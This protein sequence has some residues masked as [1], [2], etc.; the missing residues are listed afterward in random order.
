[1]SS[2][3][4]IHRRALLIGSA[5]LATAAAAAQAQGRR[6][7]VAYLTRSGNTR[8]IAKGIARRLGVEPVEIATVQPYPEDYEA[9][10]AL[11]Q[12]QREGG[13]E[14]PL[15]P[16]RL[17]MAA[18]DTLFLGFPIWG[19]TAPAPIRSFLRSIDLPGRTL[20]PFIT[21]GGYG[22]GS[23]LAVIDAHA[24]AARRLPPFVLECDQERRTLE[25]VAAW[26]DDL[27]R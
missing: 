22:I 19:T 13:I 4:P 24:P 7:A 8:V 10:V 16:L 18:I 9:H 26:M 11:A 27:P 1:M 15:R 5:A 2:R 21:H 20:V 25:T 14:P 3:V 17:D 23:S 6:Q 12:Q